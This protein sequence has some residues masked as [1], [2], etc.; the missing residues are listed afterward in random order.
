[1]MKFIVVIIM[2]VLKI[3]VIPIV[4]IIALANIPKLTAMMEMNVQMTLA[5]PLLA[6]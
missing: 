5:V 4:L 6:V 3:I 1:M 2:L